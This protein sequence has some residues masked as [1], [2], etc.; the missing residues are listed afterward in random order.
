MTTDPSVFKAAKAA[1][2]DYICVTPAVKLELTLD[3]SPPQSPQV[4]TDP[5]VFKAAKAT[6]VDHICVTPEVKLDPEGY[7]VDESPP[8]PPQVTTDPSLFK[9]EKAYLV[10][11]ICVTPEDITPLLI[12]YRF[13][14][15]LYGDESPPSSLSPQVT[16]D[17]SFFKAAKARSV[18][19]ICITSV[20]SEL[21]LDE[22][23]P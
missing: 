23:P 1:G 15:A 2:V 9:A 5:S 7:K 18:E 6:G 16:T 4:T 11:N 14:A 8:L 10:E 21:T 13:D 22:F 20:K 3:A 17:L 12:P 19:N